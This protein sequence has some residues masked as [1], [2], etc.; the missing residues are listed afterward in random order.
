M[1]GGREET[2]EDSRLRSQT[3]GILFKPID[4][5]ALLLVIETAVSLGQAR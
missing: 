3:C 5:D 2:E 1:T 4:P